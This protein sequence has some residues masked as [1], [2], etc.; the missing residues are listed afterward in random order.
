MDTLAART[1]GKA[2]YNTNDIFGA[3]R[4]A[5]DDSR[6][7]YQLGYYP[8]NSKWDGS[9]HEIEIETKRPDVQV[10]A[11]KGYF[12][13]PVPKSTPDSRRDALQLAAASP[14]DPAQIAI[15]VHIS[16]ADVP[17]AQSVTLAIHFDSRA[18][19]FQQKDAKWTAAIETVVVQ[20]DS[21]GKV[22]TGEQETFQ[23]NLPEDRYQQ[24]LRDG[25]DYTKTFA[26]TTSATEIRAIVRDTGSGRIGAV[27]IPLAKYFPPSK[28][29]N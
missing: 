1:G 7:T 27:G 9:F 18:I 8:E 16:A 20:R 6:F 22:L 29:T 21:T 14:M 5:V 3:V 15:T 4:Q 11:R 12:A 17:G 13:L 24:I 25:A 2:F 26:V 19:E 28:P 23:L 10:R